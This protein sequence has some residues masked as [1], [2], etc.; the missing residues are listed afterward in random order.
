MPLD[1]RFCRRRARWLTVARACARNHA[2]PHG[3]SWWLLSGRRSCWQSSL[4]QNFQAFQLA[5]GVASGVGWLRT[6]WDIGRGCTGHF[7]AI[8]TP[9]EPLKAG[10]NSHGWAASVHRPNSNAPQERNRA[11]NH[12]CRRK[13]AVAAGGP[14]GGGNVGIDPWA[15]RRLHVVCALT[16]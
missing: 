6:S 10:E 9:S 12:T 16:P 15:F 13:A 4:L 14:D 7:A 3:Q 8:K 2:R 1:N 11:N 5:R